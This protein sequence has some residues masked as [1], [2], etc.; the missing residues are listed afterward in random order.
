MT[1]ALIEIKDTPAALQASTTPADLLRL[2]VQSGADLDRL[3]KLMELQERWE[4]AEAVKAYRQ[5]FTAFRAEAVRIIK[6]KTIGAGPLN[7]RKYAS[8]QAVITS[9][10][11]ALS[12]HGLAASWSLTIDRADWIEVC[13]KLSHV[14]GHSEQVTMGGPPDA[15]GAKNA[16]QARASTVS[17]LERYTLKAICGVSE[18][19][20]DD[21]GNSAGPGH[22]SVGGPKPKVD[23]TALMKARRAIADGFA[24]GRD[25]GALSEWEA[26]CDAGEDFAGDVWAG[27]TSDDREKLRAMRNEGSK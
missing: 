23:R 7:G 4:R 18:S 17:Y 16:I 13:C 11:P 24:N 14:S 12:A 8:L 21:D 15:G 22:H 6:D 25:M 19:D 5:A 2:A 9:I 26:A 20:D 1:D 10:T 27:L 3:E